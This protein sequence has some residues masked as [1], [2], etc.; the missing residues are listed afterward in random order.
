M[1]LLH[2]LTP[3][4]FF[5]HSICS[6]LFSSD[7]L[8]RIS[9]TDSSVVHSDLKNNNVFCKKIK[10]KFNLCNIA[11]VQYS[12]LWMITSKSWLKR[13][14]NVFK[15]LFQFHF[16]CFFSLSLCLS[17]SRFPNKKTELLAITNK[18]RKYFLRSNHHYPANKL[19]N[20]YVFFRHFLVTNKRN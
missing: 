12:Y 11:S 6:T 5:N 16:H 10:C 1:T 19:H 15:K 18:T 3:L 14:E 20:N 17:S 9:W 8:L 4:L 7:H 13:N 2:Y